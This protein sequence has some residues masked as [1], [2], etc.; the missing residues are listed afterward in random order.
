MKI[1]AGEW[2]TKTTRE[3]YPHQD[4]FIQ[5]IIIHQH[6]YEGSGINDIA[7]LILEKPV[8]LGKTIGTVCLPPQ[9]FNFDGNNNCSVS[10][11]GQDSYNN[12][13]L[14]EIL[15]SVELPI[16]PKE[17]CQ[18]KLRNTDLGLHFVLDQSFVCAGGVVGMDACKGICRILTIKTFC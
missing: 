12:A 15:K 11:W 2:D 9:S 1:R 14:Q 7:L 5:E 10:G 4:R 16:V 13:K 8:D 18:A 17:Q 6:Y 3:R